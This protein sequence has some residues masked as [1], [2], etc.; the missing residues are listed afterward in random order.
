MDEACKGIQ[1]Y[2]ANQTLDPKEAFATATEIV[3][4]F[5]REKKAFDR[6][7]ESYERKDKDGEAPPA[8]KKKRKKAK[9]V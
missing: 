1:K 8:G 4:E 5:K 9:D 3:G 7:I 2:L 6:C